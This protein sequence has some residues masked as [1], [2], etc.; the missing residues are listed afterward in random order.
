MAPISSHRWF[1]LLG[2]DKQV[3]HVAACN[4]FMCLSMCTC[5]YACI[6]M[7]ARVYVRMSINACLYVFQVLFFFVAAAIFFPFGIGALV[8][9]WFVS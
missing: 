9:I 8:S 2:N 3:L 7:C 1:V 6:I 5:M 4:A